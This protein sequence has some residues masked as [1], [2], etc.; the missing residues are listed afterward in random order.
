MPTEQ[1]TSP[2]WDSYKLARAATA[3]IWIAFSGLVLAGAKQF[4]MWGQVLAM[5]GNDLLLLYGQLHPHFLRYLLVSPV[6]VLSDATGYQP[7]AIFSGASVLALFLVFLA[8]RHLDRVLA[9]TPSEWAGTWLSFILCGI[10]LLMNGRGVLALLGYAVLLVSLVP[11]HHNYSPRWWLFISLPVAMLCCSVSSGVLAVGFLFLL[12][13]C[14][15]CVL[16]HRASQNP[17][18]T[19]IALTACVATMTLYWNF[20]LIGFQKNLTFYGGGMEGMWNMLGHGAGKVMTMVDPFL[21]ILVIPVLSIAFFVALWSARVFAP[22]V[23]IC[24]AAVLAAS[25]GGLFGFTTLSVGLVP[26]LA[27]VRLL[28]ARPWHTAHSP[29]RPYDRS[30]ATRPQ[31]IPGTPR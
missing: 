17:L 31:V 16:R 27:M 10:A 11:I 25:A 30:T 28:F 23:V 13:V 12:A 4:S 29:S 2:T 18:N 24:A 26:V 5:Q 19:V 9:R 22:A 21:L 3:A 8:I 6:F 7:D 1:D 20:L 14:L 15:I